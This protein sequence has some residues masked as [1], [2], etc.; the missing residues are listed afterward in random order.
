MLKT[1][2][3]V[4]TVSGE[5]ASALGVRPSDCILPEERK[6]HGRILRYTG[7]YRDRR[8]SLAPPL[9]KADDALHCRRH[10]HLHDTRTIG[11]R[12][13]REE[14][15]LLL[16]FSGKPAYHH[17]PMVDEHLRYPETVG[18]LVLLGGEPFII[19]AEDF[20]TGQSKQ[21]RR[22]GHNDVL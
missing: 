5:T 2:G 16:F 1:T 7:A 17:V 8:H 19:K 14:S 21:N 4:H 10:L 3:G 20:S 11:I 13:D 6:S 18:I 12:I 15:F 9:E 22:M